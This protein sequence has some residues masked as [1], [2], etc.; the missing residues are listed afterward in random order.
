MWLQLAEVA[1]EWE[2]EGGRRTRSHFASPL[3]SL[4]KP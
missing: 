3:Y 4:A 1:L 2:L